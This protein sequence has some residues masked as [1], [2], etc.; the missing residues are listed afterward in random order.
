MLRGMNVRTTTMILRRVSPDGDV[1]ETEIEGLDHSTTNSVTFAVDADVEEGDE[2]SYQLPN[3]KTKTMVLTKIDIMRSPFKHSGSGRLDHTSAKY[4]VAADHGIKQPPKVSLPGLHAD[5]SSSS[6]TKFAQ[7]HHDSAVFEAFKAIEHRVQVLTGSSL[8]GKPLMSSAFSE[9]NPLLDIS[10]WRSAGRQQDDEL[11]GYKFL[12][13]GG[14]VGLRN[15]RGH[16]GSLETSEEDALEM[17]AI[18][19]LLMRALDR[20]EKRL[21]QTP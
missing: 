10:S 4:S 2:V 8:S 18:A 6:G 1:I 7:G 11:E 5:I 20:A 17:L 15:V 21:Q 12:F 19:S 9:Q 16:G 13:M 14:I 3:G